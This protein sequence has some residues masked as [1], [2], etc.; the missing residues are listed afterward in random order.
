MDTNDGTPIERRN[1]GDPAAFRAC[2]GRF[3]TGVA[4]ASCRAEGS[5]PVA[6][7]GTAITVNS[8]AS[9]SLD[10]PLAL[11]CL[12]ESSATMESF[13][14]AGHFALNIL[15]EDQRAISDRYARDHRPAPGDFGAP[16]RS[17]APILEGAL[18]VADCVLHD[19]HGGGDHRIL[20]GRVV[21]T[22]W[23]EGARPLLY[24]RG[25]Y[26]SMGDSAS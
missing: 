20:V 3:A 9:L 24:Y 15:A 25:G 7:N 4:V 19:V 5:G 12:E 8:V 2:F 22:A 14:R 10:P 6:G 16:W 23:R 1:G 17:G 21:E 13:L 11:F 18:A 26:G